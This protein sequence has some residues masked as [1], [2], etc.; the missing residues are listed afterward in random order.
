MCFGAGGMWE[1]YLPLSFVVNLKLL[2]KRKT[3]T[4]WRGSCCAWDKTAHDLALQTW[5]W[6]S[7][8][9]PRGPCLTT[10]PVSLSQSEHTLTVN[11]GAIQSKNSWFWKSPTGKTWKPGQSTPG[12]AVH[13][14]TSFFP[15]W[16]RCHQGIAFP[17]HACTR[18]RFPWP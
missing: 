16:S 8:S 10:G 6:S 4:E 17:P 1:I 13:V 3:H 9:Y 2:Q 11:P 14:L 5:A 12:I 18:K 15:L 7:I